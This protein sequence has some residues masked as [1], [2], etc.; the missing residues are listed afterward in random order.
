MFVSSFKKGRWRIYLFIAFI[1]ELNASSCFSQPLVWLLRLG[2]PPQQL[3]GAHRQRRAAPDRHHRRRAPALPIIPLF[4]VHYSS[5]LEHWSVVV[6]NMIGFIGVKSEC[7]PNHG[8]DYLS[9]PPLEDSIVMNVSENV[10]LSFGFSVLDRMSCKLLWFLLLKLLRRLCE[11]LESV[12]YKE[13]VISWYIWRL[14]W[15]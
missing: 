6:L 8:P 4:S 1:N 14:F 7:P 12:K 2:Q 10:S 5:A 9:D 11:C 13:K 3:H 15:L